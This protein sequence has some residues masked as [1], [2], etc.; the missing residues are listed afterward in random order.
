M[1]KVNQKNAAFYDNIGIKTFM[2]L[3]HAGGFDSWIDLQNA[4]RYIQPNERILE[5]GAGYG[6]C[7]DFLLQKEHVGTIYAI[8]QSTVLCDYL[9]EKYLDKA[10]IIEGDI[11][12]SYLPERVDAALWMWSGIIDF[13][14][15][16]QIHTIN[17]IAEMLSEKGKLFIDVPRLGVK[18][19][20]VHTD[21]QQLK[22]KTEF[23]E[24][25]CYIPNE[26]EIKDAALKS[27]FRRVDEINYETSTNKLRTMYIL[28]K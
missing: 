2:D 25:E 19:I 4:Y 26:F 12:K 3:S 20:A 28:L 15:E 22:M 5:I 13:S 6:R 27:G 21:A 7:I 16:E 9:R 17:H 18:T 10:V 23:G 24:M 8:E 11:Y 14:I 1:A